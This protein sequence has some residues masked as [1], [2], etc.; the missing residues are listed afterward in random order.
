[1]TSAIPTGVG[2]VPSEAQRLA[3]DIRA[4]QDALGSEDVAGALRVVDGKVQLASD[5]KARSCLPNLFPQSPQQ[6]SRPTRPALPDD[7]D[8]FKNELRRAYQFATRNRG[9]GPGGTRGEHWSWMPTHNPEAFAAF[10]CISTRVA[11]GQVPQAMLQAHLSARVLVTDRPEDDKVQPLVL[12]NFHQRHASKAVSRTFDVRVAVAL[13]PVEY[14]LSGGK[15]PEC[16]HKTIPLDLDTRQAIKISFDCI[17]ACAYIV[18]FGLDFILIL[19][20]FCKDS[21]RKY[22]S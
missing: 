14:S 13:R 21:A 19:L 12:G 20:R 22:G 11:L 8:R 10:E 16:M 2:M 5:S 1:M 6:P 3:K 15:G 4:I 18:D 17:N 7:I 9:A